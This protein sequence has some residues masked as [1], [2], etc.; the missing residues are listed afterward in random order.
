MDLLVSGFRKCECSVSR[1]E[2]H[3]KLVQRYRTSLVNTLEEMDCVRLTKINF[4]SA[5]AYEIVKNNFHLVTRKLYTLLEL[6]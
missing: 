5:K 1:V 6:T 4:S 3:G 2:D